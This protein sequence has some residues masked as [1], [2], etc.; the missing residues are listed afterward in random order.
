M[1]WEG[2]DQDRSS[3][4]ASSQG[5][6]T[7]QGGWL[8]ERAADHPGQEVRKSFVGCTGWEADNPESCDQT[9]PMPQ[10]NFYEVTPLEE[11]C[12]VC[13]RTRG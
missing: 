2:M 7:D 3:G 11:N 10:P 1:I 4:P 13:H 9:F 8:A 5:S 6:R 12:S